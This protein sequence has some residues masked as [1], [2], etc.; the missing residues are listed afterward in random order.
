[1][2]L[3]IRKKKDG[4]VFVSSRADFS[5]PPPVQHHFGTKWLEKNLATGVASFT[6]GQI[7]LHASDGDVA[8][9]VVRGP[10]AFCCHCDEGLADGPA[11]TPEEAQR[12]LT[13]V[14]EC[15]IANNTDETGHA[16]HPAGYEVADYYIGE[17]NG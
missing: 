7:I 13:H 4:A 10:G 2:G 16:S 3:F 12:R 1:M 6:D 8:Y 15:Q 11:R 17:L 14:E 5:Q 9:D